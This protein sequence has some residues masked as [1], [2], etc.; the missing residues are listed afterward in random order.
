MKRFPHLLKPCLSNA[1]L[2]GM[3][4]FDTE[5]FTSKE[6]STEKVQ[7]MKLWTAVY[8]RYK[9]GIHTDIEQWSDGTTTAQLAEFITGCI[10][11]KSCVYV[12]SS[13]IWFDLRVSQLFI[14]LLQSG[15]KVKSYFSRGKSFQLVMR[16]DNRTIR[17][18]NI[19]NILTVS[20]KK[21]GEIIDLPKLSVDFEKVSDK[22][23]LEYCYRDTEII[24]KSMLKWF[25]FIIEHD[26]GTFG[27]TLPTQAFNAY[28]HRFMDY[29]IYIH[30]NVKVLALER[31][32]YFGGRCECFFIGKRFKKPIY[33]LDINSMYPYMMKTKRMPRKLIGLKYKISIDEAMDNAQ[34]HC[35][36]V[37]CDIETTQPIY[38]LRL[39][40]KTIFPVGKF[41]TSLC[42]GSFIRAV[43][44]GHVKRITLI[45]RYVD[46]YIFTKWVTELYGIRLK[47]MRT[48]NK[49]YTEL[50][51]RVLNQLYGK[52]GQK[53]DELIEEHF[54]QTIAFTSE[55]MYN[56]V[57]E[58]WVTVTHLG[59]Y[60]K[61][62][63]E[64]VNEGSQSFPAISAHVTDY[65]RLYL[66]DMTVK[67]GKQ[68]VYY[69]DTDC[70]FVNQAG[71]D[72]LKTR[73]H[74]TRLGAFKLEAKSNRLLIHGPK[75]YEFGEKKRMKGVSPTAVEISPGTYSFDI[76]PGIKGELR[77]SM[78][79]YYSIK[80]IQK[81]LKRVYDKGTVT[82]SGRVL[83]LV[84][85]L[86]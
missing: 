75:D 74:K 21:M 10:R 3:V 79:K 82:A 12:F 1:S 67:A 25:D 9:P 22:D 6:T 31:R 71:Y 18:L 63:I 38:P 49:V 64:G 2:K 35:V 85:P 23:L 76:F 81:T 37:D 51:K 73:L 13:N 83:P 66:W 69:M 46:D 54:A 16:I 28:R 4:F 47:Y 39:K 5:T 57:I 61:T 59:D 78:S 27:I 62:I 45:A 48:K 33:Y 42:T 52:W 56:N 26:L 72:R 65:A 20:V 77:P 32:A 53:S 19:Q 34:K 36:V 50:M 80:K 15:W 40:N 30:D 24:Y 86:G 29:N 55:R 58:K 43:K 7:D 17:F 60:E 14:Y 8:Y 11:V 41:S 84:F 70:L 44:L 68:N